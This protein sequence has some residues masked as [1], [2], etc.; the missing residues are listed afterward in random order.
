MRNNPKLL[1]Q[2]IPGDEKQQGKKELKN[3][4]QSINVYFDNKNKNDTDTVEQADIVLKR[5][6][7]YETMK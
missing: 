4:I 5:S 7:A 2:M 6:K 1:M 3:S